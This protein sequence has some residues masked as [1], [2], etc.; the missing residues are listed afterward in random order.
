MGVRWRLGVS[1]AVT[2]AALQSGCATP[3][4]SAIETA[5]LAAPAQY[6]ASF[7]ATGPELSRPRAEWWREL[8]STELD[9]LQEIALENNKDL[10]VAIARV[11]QAD[12]S[13]RLAEAGRSPTLEA[14]GRRENRGPRLGTGTAQSIDDWHTRNT[15]QLG[16]RVNYEADL[17]GKFGYAVESALALARASAHQRETVALTL[18]G[19]VAVTYL[20]YLSLLDRISIAERSLE[21][22]RNTL[23]AVIKRQDKGDGTSLETA[24]QRVAVANAEANLA[25][26]AQ[27]RDR[28]FNR[29][30]LLIGLA[31]SALTLEARGLAGVSIP[32]A[33]PGV[34][35]ELLCRRPDVRRVEEQ[36]VSAKFDVQSLRANLLPAVS[37]SGEIGYGSWSLAT[38]TNP[39]SVFLLAAA[40]FA[41][42]LSDAGRKESQIE[43]ARAKHLE[44]V[45][46]YA[47]TLLTA[48]RE[49]ED[50]LVGIRLTEEQHRALVEA[51]NASKEAYALSLKYF[52]LGAVDYLTV[53]DSEQKLMN[54]E[55]ASESALFDRMRAAVDL[56]RSL[57]GGTQVPKGERCPR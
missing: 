33:H 35:A 45:H 23:G 56:F 38:L 14:F 4:S 3:D 21:N 55:D 7:P 12:A 48:V 50:A 47:G 22:R 37:L 32:A 20:E 8:V 18:T 6:R 43:Q 28:A 16:A 27:R 1:G 15:F 49:V 9:R 5:E 34:P 40:S 53:L 46:Q 51:R 25:S 11:A 39:A 57:G 54:G 36:I 29:L 24:Q 30:A 31:P 42:T 19:D 52:A 26:L 2:L 10:Q 41:Q 44:L 13:A 17:W